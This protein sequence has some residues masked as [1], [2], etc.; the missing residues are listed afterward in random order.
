MER[1]IMGLKNALRLKSFHST[2]LDIRATRTTKG[3]PP[4]LSIVNENLYAIK[5][6]VV[7]AGQG[8]SIFALPVQVVNVSLI[9]A[10]SAAE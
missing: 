4:Y 9:R 3:D 1:V 8:G 5:E 6:P 2:E 10:I 7:A